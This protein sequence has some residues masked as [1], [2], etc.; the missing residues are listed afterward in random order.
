MSFK[1]ELLFILLHILDGI[2]LLITLKKYDFVTC[3][4]T[5]I[6]ELT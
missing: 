1:L 2:K 4:L 5:Q 6:E 3:V